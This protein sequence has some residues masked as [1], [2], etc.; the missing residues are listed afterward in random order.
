MSVHDNG[1]ELYPQGRFKV[2]T[3]GIPHSTQPSRDRKKEKREDMTSAGIRRV[4][5]LGLSAMELEFVN[6]VYL[7]EEGAREVRESAEKFRIILTTHA[8][9]FINLANPGKSVR[10]EQVI[11]HA[12][13]ICA[14]AGVKSLVLHPAY[15]MG[16]D[17][18]IVFQM[19]KRS[20]EKIVFLSRKKGYNVEIRPETAG[21]ISQFGS[22]DELIRLCKEVEGIK[23]C[24]DFAHIYARSGGQVNGYD[25]FMRILER[26]WKELGD[27]ALQDL[28]CHVE[29]I[30]YGK[31]GEVRHLDFHQ[32]GFDFKGLAKALRNSGGRGIII[33]ESPSLEYDA[34]IFL[35]EL[36]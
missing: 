31:S 34:L 28:H 23:P 15:Y 30:E 14:L 12:L 11:L 22:L 29:G 19:V 20:L 27:E 33:C 2:G 35:E 13:K 36:S 10:S 24:I 18:E 25:N 16:Q 9:Y 8:P 6:G 17:P 21:K 1:V 3:A 32:S 7:A 26:I 5:E 4:Y